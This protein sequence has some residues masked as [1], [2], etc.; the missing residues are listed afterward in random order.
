MRPSNGCAYPLRPV[1]VHQLFP[2]IGRPNWWG[3]PMN[4]EH[5]YLVFSFHWFP[6]SD[7]RPVFGTIAVPK[8]EVARVRAWFD[9]VVWP[10]ARSWVRDV[11]RRKPKTE[12]SKLWWW[13]SQTGE[14]Y[15]K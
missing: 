12:E 14:S 6:G 3:Q 5:I 2:G 8:E 15:V 11:K 9:A 7:T 13:D 1:E 4:W 10:E